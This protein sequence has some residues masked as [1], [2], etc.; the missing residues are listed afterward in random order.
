MGRTSESTIV[1]VAAVVLL[2][3]SLFPPCKVRLQ[4]YSEYSRSWSAKSEIAW[5]WIGV[6][7]GDHAEGAQR[8]FFSLEMSLRTDSYGPP[9]TRGEVL[10]VQ[11]ALLIAEILLV[12][13]ATCGI[14]YLS[15]GRNRGTTLP[16]SRATSNPES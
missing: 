3:L 11:G 2:V 10:E 14:L 13:L 16:Q 7:T 4:A 1:I 6:A 15:S 8:H 9:Q 5:L 12:A